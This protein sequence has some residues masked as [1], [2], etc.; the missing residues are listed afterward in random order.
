MN[1]RR[2][3]LW[4]DA[5]VLLT[6]VSTILGSCGGDDNAADNAAEEAEEPQADIASV[7]LV[8]AFP[9]VTFDAPT[10][11]APIPGSGDAYVVLERA[12]SVFRLDPNGK[13][14]IGDLR[15]VP[16]AGESGLLNLAFSP[17]FEQNNQV[18]VYYGIDID[19]SDRVDV[20]GQLSRFDLGQINPSAA[21]SVLTITAISR[22]AT[23]RQSAVHNGGGLAFDAA[24]YLYLGVGDGG[25]RRDPNQNG[26]D[27]G[28]LAGKVLRLDVENIEGDGNL[29][30][31]DNPF[32]G[33]PGC[34]DGCDE[35]FAYGFR[36]PWRLSFDDQGRLWV[37]D[38]GEGAFEEVNLVEAGGNYGWSIMEGPECHRTRSCDQ[39]GLIPPV[40]AYEHGDDRGAISGGLVYRG[41]GI[42]ELAGR[43]VY[44]DFENGDVRATLASEPF[45][46]TVLLDTDLALVS[47]AEDF[48]GELLVVE[49]ADAA[50]Q[51]GGSSN[52]SLQTE[53]GSLQAPAA[54]RLG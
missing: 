29:V 48:D 2:A 51:V 21:T 22:E 6:V 33:T 20:A 25:P 40:A 46:T 3:R 1:F 43:Y 13:Q 4:L 26:Q 24:G 9:G 16:L 23:G 19:P 45:T 8:E 14:Q 7:E 12:G 10:A 17:N 18:Y 35:I 32:V 5:A 47:F 38:V 44:A 34:A 36:N 39:T 52:W 42:P 49:I 31:R 50:A 28:T 27:T 37:A 11:I 41:D 53:V 30:P 54:T 15:P